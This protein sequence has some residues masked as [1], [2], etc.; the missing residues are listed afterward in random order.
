MHSRIKEFM[1]LTTLAYFPKS[2]LLG[3]VQWR[4]ASPIFSHAI[5]NFE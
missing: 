2:S 3:N 4:E 5:A 1:A